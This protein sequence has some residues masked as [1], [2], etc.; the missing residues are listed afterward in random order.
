MP[1]ISLSAEGICVE[2]HFSVFKSAAGI[3]HHCQCHH[4]Q[5]LPA[6][7]FSQFAQKTL[8]ISSFSNSREMKLYFTNGHQVSRDWSPSSKFTRHREKSDTVR[9]HSGIF[10]NHFMQQPLQGD[11]KAAMAEGSESKT[12]D[13]N[14]WN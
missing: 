2:L 4:Y 11:C 10:G 5:G 13:F 9:C 7:S 6:E 3:R 1:K 12:A 14:V 8:S